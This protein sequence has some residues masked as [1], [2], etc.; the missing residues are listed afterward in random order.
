MFVIMLLLGWSMIVIEAQTCAVPENLAANNLTP[1]SADLTW[2]AVSGATFYTLIYKRQG[3][4]TWVKVDTDNNATSYSLTGLTANT[5]YHFSVTANCVIAGTSSGYSTPFNFTIPAECTVPSNM[6]ISSIND[7]S[8]SLNWNP[9]SGAQS[10]T[11]QY[12]LQN[13]LNSI[14]I[15]NITNTNYELTGLEKGKSYRVQVRN[16]CENNVHSAYS[17]VA[18]FTA[19][20]YELS[21]KAIY[22]GDNTAFIRWAPL[23]FE[24][25]E[26]GNENGYRLERITLKNAAGELGIG[27]QLASRVALDSSMMPISVQEWELIA[28]SDSMAGIAAGLLY[29]DS[30]EVVNYNDLS[31]TE[32]ANLTT[33][34]ETRFGFSLFAADNSFPVAIGV[35][36]GFRD[37]SVENSHEYLYIVKMNGTQTK[38]VTILNTDSLLNLPIPKNLTAVPGD[39]HAIIS[40]DKLDLDPYYTSYCVEQSSDGGENFYPAHD[41]PLIFSTSV[42]EN[43]QYASFYDSLAQNGVTYVY[44]VK[45]KSPWGLMGPYSDTISVIGKPA[46]LASEIAILKIE[47]A[48]TYGELKITWRFPIED[49]GKINDFD[50][51]RA[52]AIDGEYLMITSGLPSNIREYIDTE[53][54]AVNYYKIKTKDTNGYELSSIALLGQ[55]KDTIAPS[56]PD[57]ISGSC[58]KNG[59]VTLNWTINTEPDIMGYRVFMSNAGDGDFTQIT[60]AWINNNSF[61]YNINLKTL[62]EKVYFAVKVLDYRENTSTFSSP[63]EVMRP[64]II[65]PAPPVISSVVAEPSKVN[66]EWV[67]SSSDDVVLYSFQRKQQGKS[68]WEDILSFVPIDNITRFQD[69]TA[70]YLYWYNY[71]L[72]AKDDA[73]LTASSKVVKARPVD[74]GLRDSIENLVGTLVLG[75][76][77]L[78]ARYVLLS[79]DYDKNAIDLEGFQIYR[80][81]DSSDLR[82]YKFITL[83]QGQQFASNYGATQWAFADYDLDF[84]NVKVQNS[85]VAANGPITNP[86]GN[87]TSG[88]N[89]VHPISPNTASSP[90]NGTGLTYRVMAKFYNGATS[91]LSIPISIFIP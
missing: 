47:D 49:E 36:L 48:E 17:S 72:L 6:Q 23:D 21:A 1:N 52:K 61:S 58:D 71:R 66:F 67:L 33:E 9:A 65:P 57:G 19:R 44:R 7:E 54:N 28:Q 43:P 41:L 60:G 39:R 32:V 3:E 69:T 55:P 79:W 14:I 56:A 64:D 73:G 68:K 84:V 77:S 85:Y 37:E 26:K 46:P 82:A 8:A 62:S 29:G 78:D 90:M 11:L 27:D 4:D 75:S 13:E 5:E 42:T 40:W 12:G 15:E 20:E 31:F 22:I 63:C 2:G 25:W 83:A 87:P 30:L 50:V 91:P 53:P 34:R 35:G 70:S 10:Y 86:G 51:Y 74:N 59:K 88:T 76:V 81:I 24:S 18:V 89:T 80:G 16:D 45:G 38:A